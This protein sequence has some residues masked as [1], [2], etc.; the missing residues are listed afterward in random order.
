MFVRG[1]RDAFCNEG[2]WS[3]ICP[4][5]SSHHLVVHEMERGDH[6][7]K[8]PG[9]AAVAK[10]A[11]SAAVKAAL[12]FCINIATGGEAPG[13]SPDGDSSRVPTGTGPSIGKPV[14]QHSAQKGSD[15]KAGGQSPV[16]RKRA[17]VTGGGTRAGRDGGSAG[18]D[19]ELGKVG[20]PSG[21]AEPAVGTKGAV[22]GRHAGLQSG[23]AGAEKKGG[24]ATKGA[25]QGLGSLGTL[26]LLPK[27]QG[28]RKGKL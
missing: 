25:Q 4:R 5:L 12:A 28:H 23:K 22:K 11:L 19:A 13:V 6:S 1:T 3:S 18:Q 8:V 24:S 10:G 21:D 14:P 26:L 27:S 2:P 9:G 15:G 17:G 16:A 7:L 20:S